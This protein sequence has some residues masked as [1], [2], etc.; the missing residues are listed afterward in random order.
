ML[1]KERILNL[2]LDNIV[3]D[4]TPS[5]MRHFVNTVFDSKENIIRKVQ[6]LKEIQRV[7]PYQINKGDLVVVY[8]DDDNNGI[9]LVLKN[10]PIVDDVALISG[11][12]QGFNELLETG[13]DGQVLSIED[14]EFR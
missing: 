7:Y 6:T 3:S 13:K 8:D 12:S 14:G 10:N 5:D 4:I 2:F 9:Y 11:S 1:T